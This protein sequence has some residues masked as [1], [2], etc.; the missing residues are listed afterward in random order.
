MHTLKC[1]LVEDILPALNTLEILLTDIPNIQIVGSSTNKDD[2]INK[3]NHYK[4][5]LLFMDIN[6]GKHSGF[7]VLDACKGNYKFVIFTT[8]YNEYL[9][10]SFDYP[11]IHYLLKPIKKENLIQ[12]IN[13]I[14]S[15]FETTNVI[16]N[17]LQKLKD[18]TNDNFKK[19]KFYYPHKGSWKFV[20]TNDIIYIESENSYSNIFT[21]HDTIKVS[22]NLSKMLFELSD[23]SEENCFLRIHKQYIININYIVEIKKGLKSSVLLNNKLEFPISIKQKSHVF[24]VLGV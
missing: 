7:E 2:A 6:L 21:N 16:E 23:I 8:A 12:A 14:K 19:G 18:S 20:E 15:N 1:I 5:D 4:P 10:K 17:D 3:I 11:T 24:S 13:K 9:L 22:K